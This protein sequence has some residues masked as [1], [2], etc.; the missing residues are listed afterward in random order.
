MRR[1]LRWLVAS[2]WLVYLLQPL[3]ALFRQP[4]VA[5]M[6]L[7]LVGLAAFSLIYLRTIAFDH[8]KT[9]L[10][11]ASQRRRAGTRLGTIAALVFTTL[12]VVPGAGQDALTCLVFVAAVAMGTLPE[13]QAFCLL[14]V[15]YLVAEGT[16]RLVPG[17]TNGTIGFAVL[18]GGLATWA[19][20]VSRMRQRRLV[21]AEHELGQRA[22][23]EQ[24]SRI[25]N[26]LH[27]ILGHSLT[28]ISVKTELARRLLDIDLDQ[29][30]R[31]LDDLEGLTRDALADVRATAL[32]VRGVSLP[33]EIAAARAALESAGVEAD[34]PT[35]TDA[36]PSRW[37]ELFAWTVREG[38]TN[39][40]RHSGAEHC[41]VNLSA[42]GVR[43]LDDGLGAAAVPA[44]DYP[45]GNGL[46]GL[47]QRAELLGARL[48][49][50]P[51]RDGRGFSL[52]VEVPA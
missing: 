43:V 26:D 46:A 36:V 34:L 45:E 22:L 8:G 21:E 47:R 3:V 17:W 33:G 9:F 49:A 4:N 23:E 39:V 19:F 44:H 1:V 12:L 30:R 14:A 51:R 28:V 15:L 29:A 6:V 18:L 5:F 32:G 35:T 48:E 50:G 41:R 38:V 24:R 7:G 20:R 27:D 11:E 2:V 37:R 13:R 40:L 16:G 52:Y 42:S 31:E 10:W 25:A